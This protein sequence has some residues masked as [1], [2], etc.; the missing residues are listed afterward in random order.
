LIEN[1]R[2]KLTASLLNALAA[3]FIVTGG[4]APVVALFVGAIRAPILPV[5]AAAGFCILTGAALHFAARA[6][7]RRLVP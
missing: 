4:L 2:T 7:P 1:G 5:V 6:A 3:G